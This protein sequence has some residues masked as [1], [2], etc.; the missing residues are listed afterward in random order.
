MAY[1]TRKLSSPLMDELL[2]REGGH[3]TKDLRKCVPS[4]F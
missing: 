4:R 1:L 2:V 3:E